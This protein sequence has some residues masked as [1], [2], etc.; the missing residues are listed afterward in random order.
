MPPTHA[1]RVAAAVR[2]ESARRR[3]TQ[4][5]IAEHLGLSRMAVSRRLSGVV[6]FDA[7]ELGRTAE[8]FGVPVSVLFGEA[9]TV[10]PDRAAIKAAS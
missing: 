1:Q 6:P 4:T 3:I 8:L 5:Q 2:A 9:A 7:D 10:T